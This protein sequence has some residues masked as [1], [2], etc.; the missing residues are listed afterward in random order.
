MTQSV[1]S[2]QRTKTPPMNV[3]DMAQSNLMVSLQ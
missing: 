2:L 3:L 1:A